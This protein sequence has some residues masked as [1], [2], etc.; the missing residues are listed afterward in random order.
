MLKVGKKPM[1][2]HIIDM[3]VTH[4]FT[5]FMISVNYKS[6][7]IKEY[8]KDGEDFGIEIKYLE[9][10]KRLGTGGALSL[11][12]FKLNEPFFVTNG[13]VLASVD[14][15]K[16]L[17]FHNSEKSDGGKLYGPQPTPKAPIFAPSSPVPTQGEFSA[18]V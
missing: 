9:E 6:E 5:K 13:D 10:D 8:F 14:Y 7:V 16:L 18:M 4:G 12:D 3:F 2:E 11:I 15:E 17:E 1:I